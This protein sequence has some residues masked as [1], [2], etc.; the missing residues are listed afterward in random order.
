MPYPL[1]KYYSMC[2]CLSQH[3]VYLNF[4]SKL[5][6]SDFYVKESGKLSS[7]NSYI[8]FLDVKFISMSHREFKLRQTV[9]QSP[10]V[11]M[12]LSQGKTDIV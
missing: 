10:S 6:L 8:Q 7:T 5:V 3:E 1:T 2:M 9:T 12:F 11:R 4:S